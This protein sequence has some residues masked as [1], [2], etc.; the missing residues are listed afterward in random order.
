MVKVGERY[1]HYKSSGGDDHTYEVVHIGF[2]Q[3]KKAYEDELMV[4]YK[5][6]YKVY[7][8]PN[9]VDVF[10]RPLSERFTEEY[11]NEWQKVPRFTQI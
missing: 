9:E 1:R 7:G 3:G 5:P 4:V 11:N 10:V 8:L 6:L 2:F